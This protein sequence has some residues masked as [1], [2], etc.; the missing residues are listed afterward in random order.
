MSERKLMPQDLAPGMVLAEPVCH[1]FTRQVIWTSGTA[2]TQHHIILLQRM[3]LR[4]VRVIDMEGAP[5]G[6]VSLEGEGEALLSKA[7]SPAEAPK[8]P[9]VLR[10]TKPSAH[11]ATSTNPTQPPR[12]AKA[13]AS[14]PAPRP[15][16]KGTQFKPQAIR[17]EVLERNVQ[18]IKHLHS[19]VK[20]SNRIDIQSVDQ[21]VQ[22]TIQR[23]V[24]NKELLNSLIDLRVYDEYTYSHSSNVMSLALV[25]GAALGY[26]P[27]RLRILG[28]G[29][30]LHD[31][32]KAMI[33][34]SILHK[35]GKL[36]EEEF[37]IMATH[38]ANGIMLLS[39]YAWANTEIKNVVFQHH[40]KFDGSGYPMKLSGTAISE[41]ARIVSVVD[42]YDALISDRPYKKGL[43]P[44]VVYQA[45]INGAGNHFDP[46]IVQ[47][48]VKFIVPY[49]VNCYVEL[50]TGQI[51]RV[52]RVTRPHLMRPLIELEGSL[53][54]LSKD[55]R[56]TIV[57][58]H[59]P[60]P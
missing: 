23:I 48:F 4:A 19:Q 46:R 39:G 55:P 33:P 54:D 16:A 28:I 30:L 3:E 47:A 20:Q 24:T 50:N 17:N 38:P 58:M 2:L 7:V 57:H 1:P 15:S 35:P 41:F 14:A 44:N 5:K 60:A 26:S 36:T 25:V 53:V 18:T 31:V 42:V 34:E 11:G 10:F 59:K 12:P 45:I 22:S 27:E 51:A 21:S 43:P 49:P 52:V 32:G 9:P 56:F 37:N 40:E 13:S 6:G 8:D 29:A